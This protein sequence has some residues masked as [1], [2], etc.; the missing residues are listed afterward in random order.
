MCLSDLVVLPKFPNFGTVEDR[1]LSVV[2]GD[3]AIPVLHTICYGPCSFA[4]EP[5]TWNSL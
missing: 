5:S 4:A 3:F 1:Q 2:T